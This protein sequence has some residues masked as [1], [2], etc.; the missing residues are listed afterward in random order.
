MKFQ[1]LS[2][3]ALASLATA[4][5]AAI[6]TGLLGDISGHLNQ[7]LS[8]IQAGSQ[9]LPS[10][11]LELYQEVQTYTDDSYTTLLSQLD[12]SA[13][14]TFATALP[15]YSSRLET[16]FEAAATGDSGSSSASA[17]ST[18]NSSPVPV[19]SASSIISSITSE[20]PVSSSAAE[21]SSASSEAGSSSGA[22]SS[23]TA[24][25]ISSSSGAFSL[26]DPSN[27]LALL[28][29]PFAMLMAMPALL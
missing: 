1:L 24:V 3:L 22:E 23:S 8:Y 27:Q 2:T 21:S 16:I 26:R 15:W 19:S 14:S 28:M 13:V 12:F 20:S 9:T 4:Q 6:V 29:V 10:G 7:Y 11:V 17:T 5:E 25:A 18:L